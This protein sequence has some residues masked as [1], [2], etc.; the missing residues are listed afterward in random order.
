VKFLSNASNG[1][2]NGRYWEIITTDGT[3]YY[4]GLNPLHGWQAG[5]QVTNSAWTVP[6]VGLKAG[7]PCNTPATGTQNTY[8]SSVCDNMAWRWNLDLVVDPDGNATS[9][10]Y[11]PQTNKYAFRSTGAGGLGGTWKPYTTGG[12][13]SAIYYGSLDNAS[14]GNNVY[15]HRPFKVTLGYSGRCLPQYT[16]AQCDANHDQAHWPD[17][18]WDL[19]CPS[20][21]APGRSTG[22]R[23]SSTPRC[24]P[25]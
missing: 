20:T 18:P 2:Y 9:Y 12:T 11:T 21:R 3:Q 16:Q 7:D 6:V 23:R 25:P 13:L 1:S 19:S 8:A 15:A 5:N 22:R 4:F 24:S 14:T 10:Y 17:T